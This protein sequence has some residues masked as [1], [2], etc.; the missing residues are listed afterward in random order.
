[1][2]KGIILEGHIEWAHHP[3]SHYCTHGV[4]EFQRVKKGVP[5]DTGRGRLCPP[6][7]LPSAPLSLSSSASPRPLFTEQGICLSWDSMPTTVNN[8]AII[9]WS[10][11]SR[12]C[13]AEHLGWTIWKEKCSQTGSLPRVGDQKS[14]PRE[15][16]WPG[17]C[18]SK[19]VGEC[20]KILQATRSGLHRDF[21]CPKTP[22]EIYDSPPSI[23]LGHSPVKPWL[24]L[25][26][27]ASLEEARRH[28]NP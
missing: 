27:L 21:L 8:L 10:S 9:S 12:D 3:C 26:S 18:G 13:P 6:S 11:P 20:E 23:C 22:S 17:I 28:T 16:P 5:G 19:V 2:P 7:T 1:M 25:C 14:T 15:G 24:T 4:T